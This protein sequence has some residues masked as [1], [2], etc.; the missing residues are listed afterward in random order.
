M[1]ERARAISDG[2]TDIGGASRA[3]GVSVKMIR[4]YEAIGLLPRVARTSANY[5]IYRD[6]D[7]HTL[8]FILRARTLG[9]SI[10]EIQE[11]VGLW[12]NKSRSSAAVKKIAG[13]HAGAL[14]AKIAELNGMVR[15]LEHLSRHCHGDHRPECPILDDLAK[16]A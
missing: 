2:F 13:K 11:L 5:R 1:L 16:P 8:R 7:I 12:Q 3:S 9:F 15:T 10:K 14:K 4:H 6:S